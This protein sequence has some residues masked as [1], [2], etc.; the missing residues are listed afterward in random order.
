[1]VGVINNGEYKEEQSCFV[2]MILG[3]SPL[4]ARTW[5]ILFLFTPRSICFGYYLNTTPISVY[6]V[7]KYYQYN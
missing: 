5:I 4:L 2:F 6:F 1:M 3:N 7:C